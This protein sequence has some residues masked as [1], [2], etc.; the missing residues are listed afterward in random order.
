MISKLPPKGM[1]DFLPQRVE[2]RQALL[3]KIRQ[4]YSNYG[5]CE[6]ET[7]IIEDL[8]FLLSKQGGENEKLI[9]KILKRGEKFEKASQD[10]LCDLG[11][12]FDLTLP[13]ARYYANNI[14]AL[15][16]VA[17][18]MHIG[19]VFRADR[20][21]K[22]RFRQFVQ[23]DIDILNEPSILAEVELIA[24]TKSALNA[25][26][27]SDFTVLINDRRIL[28]S[29]AKYAGF[30]ESQWEKVFIELD[31][32]DKI[33]IESV[34]EELLSSLPKESVEK[35]F[36]AALAI[37]NSSNPLNEAQKVL[38]T[39][40]CEAAQSLQ[41]IIDATS[42]RF[43]VTLVRGMN[44]YTGT[45]FE[46]YCGGVPYALAGGGRYDKL[47]EKISG[48]PTPACGFSIGFE[49]ITEL[50]EGKIQVQK[51][52]RTAFIVDK[53]FLG[54]IKNIMRSIEDY[55]SEGVCSL[56]V[57]A[58]NFAFQVKELKEKGYGFIKV[59]DG[60]NWND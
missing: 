15:P 24:A 17:K 28:K 39:E 40:G 46:I 31:K 59:Y 48:T 11:L 18:I 51:L 34:K 2:E 53:K 9:Y 23:C 54:D 7:P 29:L 12:R 57:K 21:Q 27:L 19:S 50:L 52:P 10:D 25:I 55:R 43:D 14:S 58:K 16:P 56:F 35:F 13:L 37:K 47:I 32:L 60:N 26:G 1:R 3:F 33:G 4:A 5:F 20:P 6:I 30:E 49:R 36:G 38:D 44:Y 41:N 45:I 22:G 42:A 8:S